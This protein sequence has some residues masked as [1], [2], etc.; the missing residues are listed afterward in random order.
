MK[1]AESE[2]LNFLPSI[3]VLEFLKVRCLDFVNDFAQKYNL[4]D[5]KN[6]I[7]NQIKK[8]EDYEIYDYSQHYEQF[9]KSAK[10]Y[11]FK[12]YEVFDEQEDEATKFPITE[13]YEE[14]EIGKEENFEQEHHNLL[15]FKK[16]INC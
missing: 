4:N 9:R 1:N 10:E 16:G 11:I 3:K 2:D 5:L 7:Q 13:Q 12:S 14:E 8:K 15:H 6:R